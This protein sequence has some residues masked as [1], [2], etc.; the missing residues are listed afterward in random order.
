MA[1][2]RRNIALFFVPPLPG[3]E[4]LASILRVHPDEPVTYPPLPP[5]RE[6]HLLLVPFEVDFDFDVFRTDDGGSDTPEHERHYDLAAYHQRVHEVAKARLEAMMQDNL[7]ARW[8]IAADPDLRGFR[9]MLTSS[10]A[11]LLP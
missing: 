9:C 1:P 11:R 6:R 7:M 2:A 8:S 5:G 4:N 3:R 10:V